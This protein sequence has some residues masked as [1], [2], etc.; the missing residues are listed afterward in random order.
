MANIP[1]RDL[2]SVGVIT[3]VEPYN[4]NFSG[5][6]RAKNVRFNAGKVSRSPIFRTIKDSISFTPSFTVGQF[7]NTSYDTVLVVSDAWAIHEFSN[8][9]LTNRSGSIS[10][11]T[12]VQSYTGTSLADVTYINREDRVPVFR[13]AG[14]SNFADLTNWPSTY[15]AASLRSFGDF[16]MAFNT[17]EGSSS[18]PNRVRWS[19]IATAGAVPDSWNEADTTKSAGFNDLVQMTTPIVDAATLGSNLII[20]SQDQV[21][22]AEF[23]GGAFLF[24]FRKIFSD[25]GVINQ[26]CIVE[27]EGKHFVFDTNDIYVN[28][29]VTRQSIVDKRIK[30]Y[31]FNSLN[32]SQTDRCFVAHD[33]DLEEIYF[34]YLSGDD[35]VSFTN[36]T[37]CN[38]AAVYNYR[39]DTWSFMDL[40]NVYAGTQANLQ[41]VTT[42]ASVGQTYETVGG[43]Y[44][45]QE[46]GFDKHL[47]MVGRSDSNNGIGS[48]K[49][50]GIDL[51]D[52]G[53]LT[54]PLDT[55]ATKPIRLERTG[56]DLDETKTPLTGYKVITKISPQIETSNTDANF[57]FTFGAAS[58][59]HDDPTYG[60]AQSFDANTQYKIDTR[61]SGRYLSYKMEPITVVYKDFNFTGFD[62]DVVTTGRR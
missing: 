15:R 46:A 28:D 6:T 44:Y 16:L 9:S 47:I 37:G 2:G 55:E 39:D 54:Y 12:S 17:T 10:G 35:M 48:H 41:S 18:F 29:G 40:P 31:L 21:W 30:N 57:S 50:Y 25:A 7:S 42:Y 60:A 13:L 36:T 53:T 22:Q 27:V 51:S 3:D 23:V 24:N 34:C 33:P 19:N 4:V 45:S 5:F 43:T 49:L 1:I 58:L 20:Y 8:G 26:N 38:R 61:A 11:N 62:I 56:L 59:P 14:G 32:N 52:E